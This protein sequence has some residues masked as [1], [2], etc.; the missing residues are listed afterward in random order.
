MDGQFL[1][2]QVELHV[3][4]NL[5]AHVV[6][7]MGQEL[8]VL[9]KDMVRKGRSKIHSQQRLQKP[10]TALHQTERRG[11]LGM[12]NGEKLTKERRILQ[13]HPHI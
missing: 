7:K 2:C 11:D 13:E 3:L 1:D 6:D 12:T 5:L 4:E 10:R 9:V 8:F